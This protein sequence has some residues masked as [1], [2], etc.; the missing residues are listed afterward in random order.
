[1][2]VTFNSNTDP[3]AFD[4]A[5]YGSDFVLAP[6]TGSPLGTS[7]HVNM[8][9]LQNPPA[10]AQNVHLRWAT[11]VR[12]GAGACSYTNVTAIG[13]P[14]T[15]TGS[16]SDAAV[17]VGATA[18]SIVTDTVAFADNG[19]TLV[20][21]AGQTQRRNQQFGSGNQADGGA[22][23]EPGSATVNMAWSITDPVAWSI[24]ALPLLG[25]HGQQVIWYGG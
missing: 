14:A 4:T 1:V 17:N 25:V 16:S 5:T 23:D 21:G 10:G 6:V 2:V 20:V 11:G 8:W 15:A 9:Y 12:A 22:S 19:G 3:G 7:A 18:F 24:I 13:T